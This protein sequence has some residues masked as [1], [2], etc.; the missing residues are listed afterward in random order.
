M[1]LQTVSALWFPRGRVF[2]LVAATTLGVVT[3][4][5]HSASPP[6]LRLPWRWH[7]LVSTLSTLPL[8]LIWVEV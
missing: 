7:D 4:D 1:H 8:N 5:R 6:A 3:T 2:I